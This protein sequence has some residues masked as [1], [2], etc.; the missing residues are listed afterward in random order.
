MPTQIGYDFPSTLVV[1]YVG[2]DRFYFSSH[3]QPMPT[4]IGYYL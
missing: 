2:M 1:S 4:Q 3:V